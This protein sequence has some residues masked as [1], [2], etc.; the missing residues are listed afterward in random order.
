MM[1]IWHN[2]EQSLGLKQRIKLRE[3]NGQ[4]T[5]DVKGLTMAKRR[6]ERHKLD[7]EALS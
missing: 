3:M 7:N 4:S 5:G 2:N 1:V 6:K